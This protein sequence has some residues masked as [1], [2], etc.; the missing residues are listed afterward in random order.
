[1][2]R[3]HAPIFWL[4][5]GGG[6]MLA[7]LFG[8]ALVLVTGIAVPLA[9]SECCAY[10]RMLAFAQSL[11][12]KAFLFAVIALFAW[13]A[14]HRILCSLHDVGIHGTGR[15]A[16]LLRHRDGDQLGRRREPVAHRLLTTACSR[17]HRWRSLLGPLLPF[18][19]RSTCGVTWSQV[20]GGTRVLRPTLAGEHLGTPPSPR[21]HRVR[22]ARARATANGACARGYHRRPAGIR[23]GLPSRSPRWLWGRWFGCAIAGPIRG[24]PGGRRPQALLTRHARCTSLVARERGP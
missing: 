15:E 12:G 6:G 18:N 2:K 3:S 7:A 1:M 20:A 21:Q 5:F 8:A 23:G 24:R 16:R 10:P 22:P 14:A 9:G 19:V 4:L 13:H 17:S 11:V